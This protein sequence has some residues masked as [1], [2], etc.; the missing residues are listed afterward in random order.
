MPALLRDTEAA[1]DMNHGRDAIAKDDGAIDLHQ[2]SLNAVVGRNK[3]LWRPARKWTQAHLR[4][5]CVDRQSS[6]FVDDL[7]GV[8]HQRSLHAL[9]P[10]LPEERLKHFVNKMRVVVPSVARANAL[11]TLLRF[12]DA[13]RRSEHKDVSFSNRYRVIKLVVGSHAYRLLPSLYVFSLGPLVLPFI[14]SR[15]IARPPNIH[16]PVDRSQISNQLYEPCI[17]AVLI[18][19][20]QEKE[21]A[22]SSTD[23]SAVKQTQLLFTHFDDRQDMYVYT[24]RISEHLLDR[25]RHPNQRPKSYACSHTTPPPLIKLEHRRVPYEPHD[26]FRQRMLAACRSRLPPCIRMTTLVHRNKISRMHTM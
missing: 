10:D 6:T 19:L 1:S 25:F 13:P 14:D 22:G 4:A 11:D 8:D 12:Q 24:A 20:A 21:N 23:G 18:A 5:L 3:S 7:D 26:T 17:A 2:H 15:E 16:R 9:I